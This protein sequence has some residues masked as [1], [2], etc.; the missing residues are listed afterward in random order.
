MSYQL[1]KGS[2]VEH[3]IQFQTLELLTQ[4][5]SGLAFCLELDLRSDVLWA[6]LYFILQREILISK[7]VSSWELPYCH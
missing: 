2:L 6:D 3:A 5:F 4:G 1:R 7:L